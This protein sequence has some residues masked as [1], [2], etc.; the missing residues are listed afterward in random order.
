MEVSV[1]VQHGCASVEISQ[2]Y[3]NDSKDSIECSYQFPVDDLAAVCGFTA[4]IDGRKIVAKCM[5]KQKAQ[6]KYDGNNFRCHSHV[7]IPL[8]VVTELSC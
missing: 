5:E 8:Q 7:K 3:F 4:E 6:E 1:R 2:T